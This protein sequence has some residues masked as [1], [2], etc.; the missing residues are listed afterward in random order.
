MERVV[1]E[2]YVD[3]LLCALELSRDPPN[4]ALETYRSHEPKTKRKSLAG[5]G[6]SRRAARRRRRGRFRSLTAAVLSPGRRMTLVNSLK[7]EK[8]HKSS[9]R[10]ASASTDTIV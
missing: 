3:L 5:L 4:R 1:G 7:I 8:S 6:D 10:A 9:K 2:A